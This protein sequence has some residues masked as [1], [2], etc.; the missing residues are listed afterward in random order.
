MFDS[1]AQRFQ[2]I[3]GGQESRRNQQM[4]RNKLVLFLSLT[5]VAMISIAFHSSP[6]QP[7]G[8]FKVTNLIGSAGSG[9]PHKKDPHMINAWGNAFFPGN[10]FWIN[11]EG[12]GV[13]EL[14]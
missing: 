3:G 1:A 14:I 6:A 7:V 13:S 8:A 10:P 4:K 2:A 5:M 11:D 9:A 12:T